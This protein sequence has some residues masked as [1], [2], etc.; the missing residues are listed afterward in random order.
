MTL[1]VEGYKLK[2]ISSKA[3][4]H[5]ADR[6]ATAALKAI[7]H[8]DT[9]VRKLIEFGYE[10]ALRQAYLGSAVRLG[11]RQLPDVWAAHNRAYATLDIDAVPDLYLT[12]FPIANAMTIGAGRPIVVVQSAMVALLDIEQLRAVFGH[13]AGHVLSDHVLYS[14][15]LIILMRLTSLPGIP[16]PLFPLR[17]A[18][19]EWSRAAELTCD[20]AAALVTRDPLSVCRVLMTIAAGAEASRLDLDV[21]MTQG[22][23]YREKGSGLERLSRL[24]LDLNLTHPMPVRRIHALM[25]WVKSGDY[26]RIVDGSYVTRDEPVRP[27]AEA[28]DAVAHYAER[29]RTMFRDA[30]E[31][32]NDA[33]Q[34]LTD[35]LRRNAGDGDGR[36]GDAAGAAGAGSGSGEG[37]DEGD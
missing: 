36:A 30:G 3:Y 26:D 7:P 6:A 24:L 20:R 9:V 14:T 19:L 18:L 21:F 32:I 10:R 1:P 33:G 17:H 8:L 16:L 23:E 37:E 11:E 2:R 4:E 29:F 34:Q 22:L 27:R 15:A 5:P 28:S 25:E 13:E 12:Q 35:W 31:S